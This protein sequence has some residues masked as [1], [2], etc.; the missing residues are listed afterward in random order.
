MVSVETLYKARIVFVKRSIQKNDFRWAY[1][2]GL[3]S[4]S[5][6]SASLVLLQYYYSVQSW[7][8]NLACC[9]WDV[10]ELVQSAALISRGR[11]KYDAT[12]WIGKFAYEI[13]VEMCSGHAY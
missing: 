7:L 6:L 9:I 2:V 4:D 8:T 3:V 5:L 11:G 10:S 1:F 13:I 12:N